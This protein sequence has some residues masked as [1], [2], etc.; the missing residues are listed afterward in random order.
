MG[1]LALR[2]TVG[3]ETAEYTVE[4]LRSELGGH[5]ARF[6][7]QGVVEPLEDGTGWHDTLVAGEDTTCSC[8][9]HGRWGHCKHC[10]AVEVAV[11]RKWL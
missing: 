10:W 7:K 4:P 1:F 2:I 8:K 11:R 3:Q 9:G 5:A 6:V